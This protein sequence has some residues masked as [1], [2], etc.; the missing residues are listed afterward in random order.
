MHKNK[1]AWKMSGVVCEKLESIFKMHACLNFSLL[2][3]HCLEKSKLCLQKL[4]VCIHMYE[5]TQLSRDETGA[6]KSRLCLEYEAEASSKIH[7]LTQVEQ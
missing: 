6:H 2:L 3:C 5:S 4:N 1:A 7:F